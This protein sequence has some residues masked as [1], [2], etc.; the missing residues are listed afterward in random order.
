MQII[1]CAGVIA[2][3]TCDRIEAVSLRGTLMVLTGFNETAQIELLLVGEQ[4]MFGLIQV[5]IVYI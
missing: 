4:Q 3:K 2:D 1:R 5:A